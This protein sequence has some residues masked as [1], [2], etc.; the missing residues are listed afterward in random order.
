MLRLTV[1]EPLNSDLEVLIQIA[2][3][4]PERRKRLEVRRLSIDAGY[5][6]KTVRSSI[7][8]LCNAGLIRVS[9]PY[10][11]GVAYDYLLMDRSKPYLPDK[12][13]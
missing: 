10:E 7:R 11:R 5:C 13:A 12:L 1:Y 8:R 9:R 6:E 3:R 4:H 2:R